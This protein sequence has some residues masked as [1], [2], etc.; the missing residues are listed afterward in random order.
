MTASGRPPAQAGSE[1]PDNPAPP[2]NSAL[3]D[4]SVIVPAYNAADTIDAQL[5]ALAEQDFAGRW[6]LI[7]IDNASTD[8]T[9]AA[10]QQWLDRIPGLRVVRADALAG[11]SYARNTGAALARAPRLAFCDADDVAAPGWLSA[12]M[13]GLDRVPFVGGHYDPIRLNDPLR[14]RW[15][16][17]Q[18]MSEPPRPLDYLPFALTGNLGIHA[19][20][21]QAV[22]GF[23]TE[24]AYSEDADFGW[25]VQLAGFPLEYVPEAVTHWR[26]RTSAWASARQVHRFA[27]S[28]ALLYQRYRDR[29]ARRR[30]LKQVAGSYVF[31]VTRLPFL[32]M[33]EYRRGSWLV[34]AAANLGRLDGSIRYRVIFP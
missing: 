27:Q 1:P 23:D 28:H 21:F 5:A 15:P 3:P 29:G 18:P 30:T 17:G 4:V 19:E 16:A 22:G 13:A 33:S 24:F 10:A 20:V 7:V 6:E 34:V 14:R 2:D 26:H 9:G 31:L 11:A 32:A 8:G 25:R 12:I